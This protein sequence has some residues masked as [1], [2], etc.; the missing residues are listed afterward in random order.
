VCIRLRLN[1]K[2]QETKNTNKVINAG[3]PEVSIKTIADSIPDGSDVQNSEFLC[4]F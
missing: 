2:E 4:K 1:G 3:A